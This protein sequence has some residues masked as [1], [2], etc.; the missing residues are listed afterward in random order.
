MGHTQALETQTEPGVYLGRPDM[1][2]PIARFRFCLG[3]K[4]QVEQR[5]EVGQLVDGRVL[6]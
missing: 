3:Y 1:V 4:C 5:I 6:R 2:A